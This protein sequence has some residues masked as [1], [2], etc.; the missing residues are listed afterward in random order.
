VK[1]SPTHKSFMT[2]EVSRIT[3]YSA[4]TLYALAAR[5]VAKPQVMSNGVRIWTQTDVDAI[6]AH[7][8]KNR[9]RRIGFTRL[10][11]GQ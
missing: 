3:A 9:V 10:F 1:N 2:G 8:Q 11:D 4:K 5:G 6:N 7:R